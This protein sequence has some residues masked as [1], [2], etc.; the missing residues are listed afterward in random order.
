MTRRY[1]ITYPGSEI[2]VFVE[3]AE[4][5]MF[6]EGLEGS[7]SYSLEEAS[8]PR[9]HAKPKVYK[10]EAVQVIFHLD[11]MQLEQIKKDHPSLEFE[12]IA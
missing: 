9:P 1:R 11:D 8:H 12:E 7:I 5:L 10:T 3:E 6:D 4:N 2:T